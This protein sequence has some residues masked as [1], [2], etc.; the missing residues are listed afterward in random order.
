MKL[1]AKQTRLV[2]AALLGIGLFGLYSDVLLTPDVRRL[3]NKDSAKISTKI[4][5]HQPYDETC[6]LTTSGFGTGIAKDEAMR[7]SAESG[8]E[9]LVKQAL[10][11]NS[12]NGGRIVL[13]GDSNTRQMYSSFVCMA[14]TFGMWK[15]DD[16]YT[17][18]FTGTHKVP[19]D[20]RLQLK[21]EAELFFAPS[22]G[23]VQ[24]YGWPEAEQPVKGDQ[25]WLKSCHERKQFMLDTYTYEAANEKVF[26]SSGDDRFETVLMRPN[27]H[28]SFNAGLHLK[29]RKDNLAHLTEL[30]DCMA[31][32]RSKGED[33]GWPRIHY[34]RS[35]QQHFA[36][37]DG[38]YTA[39]VVK[40]TDCRVSVDGTKNPFLKEEL[41]TLSGM[42]PMHGFDLNLGDAGRLHVTFKDCSHWTMPG[43]PDVYIKE[44]LS[45]IFGLG[46]PHMSL[47]NRGEDIGV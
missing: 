3:S 28:V 11:I 21:D 26:W 27:D 41:E 22:A 37:E 43:V 47:K 44:L 6:P 4:S 7:Y 13:V 46:W 34:F 24:A 42:L 30:L 36:S 35:N 18:A 2:S 1:T 45:G 23:G 38:S 19:N 16:I 25:D 14:R 39:E 12:S 33:P 31:D 32:A 29:T 15:N 17:V 9:A 40:R 10:D 20:I 5:Q 8:A